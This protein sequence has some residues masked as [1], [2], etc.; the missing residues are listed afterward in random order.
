MVGKSHQAL[1]LEK[2]LQ[3]LNVREEESVSKNKPP[4]PGGEPLAHMSITKWILQTVFIHTYV[5]IIKEAMNLRAITGPQDE[6][7]RKRER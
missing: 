6:L 7:K 2:N 5:T 4:I 1:P 3:A